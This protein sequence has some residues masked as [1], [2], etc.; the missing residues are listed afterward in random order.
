M[1]R[2]MMELAAAGLVIDNNRVAGGE[3]YDLREESER[4][5]PM[6]MIRRT[7][8]FAAA[9]LGPRQV[10]VRASTGNLGRDGLIVHPPGIDLDPYRTNPIM[11]WQHDPAAPVARATV[12][13]IEG[14]DLVADVEFAPE[15]VS[16]KADEICGLVKAGIVNAVSIGFDPLETEPVDAKRPKGPNAHFTQRADGDFLRLGPGRPRGGRAAA[17]R[18]RRRLR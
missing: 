12:L 2:R 4:A 3:P 5:F 7:V 8:P 14:G 11:L 17:H 16:G 9:E 15:G 10:R 1:P 18:A 6:T 13:A